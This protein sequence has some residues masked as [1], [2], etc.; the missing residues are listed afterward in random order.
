MAGNGFQG[1]PPP[2]AIISA[3]ALAQLGLDVWDVCRMDFATGTGS[4][5]PS[6]RLWKLG[7][8]GATMLDAYLADLTATIAAGGGTVSQA[9]GKLGKRS[10]TALT[11]TLPAGTTTW[12]YAPVGKAF[13]E[14]PVKADAQR[15]L[16]VL[17][18]AAK[19][20]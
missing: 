20:Q 15:F 9:A 11:V 5:A 3:D 14:I 17:P 12:Y 8:G 7:K 19:G 4:D 10:V 6:G 1:F 16:K 18:K 13:A 2:P